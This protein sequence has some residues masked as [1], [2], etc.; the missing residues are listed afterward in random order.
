MQLPPRPGTRVRAELTEDL[1]GRD[2]EL[3]R[4]QHAETRGEARLPRKRA[5]KRVHERVR[6]GRGHEE[7]VRGHLERLRGHLGAREDVH[8]ERRVLA[9]ARRRRAREV[10]RKDLLEEL[11]ERCARKGRERSGQRGGCEAQTCLW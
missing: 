1:N 7:A 2:D 11:Q 5:L 6:H 3:A 4:E 10:R 8:E 9:D